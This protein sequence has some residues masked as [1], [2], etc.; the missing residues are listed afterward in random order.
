MYCGPVVLAIDLEANLEQVRILPLLIYPG[1]N[2]ASATPP[3]VTYVAVHSLLQ[4]DLARYSRA[5][6][7]ETPQVNT[8]TTHSLS[9]H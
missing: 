4:R 3:S 5:G 2:L 9:N 1:T 6:S 7:P 8:L